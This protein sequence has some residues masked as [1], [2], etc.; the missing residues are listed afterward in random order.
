MSK[1]T[2]GRNIVENKFIS[3]RNNYENLEGAFVDDL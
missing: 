2:Y 3:D 1:T